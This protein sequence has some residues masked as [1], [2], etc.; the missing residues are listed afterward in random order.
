MMLLR[1]KSASYGA[2]V[3]PPVWQWDAKRLE[4]CDDDTRDRIELDEQ[5]SGTTMPL[6]ERHGVEPGVYRLA[7]ASTA[8]EPV[9][10]SN[11]QRFRSVV[12]SGCEVSRKAPEW[13]P[14][15]LTG[16]HLASSALPAV[17]RYVMG[18]GSRPLPI[19]IQA[20]PNGEYV[21]AKYG[22]WLEV[23]K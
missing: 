19:R 14:L 8:L 10:L 16:R 7:S 11:P 15:H 2:S 4:W 17:V 20:I 5:W 12:V 23:D 21:V 1:I 22:L 6:P 9:M 13:T 18:R 3:F